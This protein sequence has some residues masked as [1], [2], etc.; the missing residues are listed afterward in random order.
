M[1]L[2]STGWTKHVAKKLKKLALPGLCFG[3]IVQY[4]SPGLLVGVPV[5]RLWLAGWCTYE[6]VE[7]LGD[8]SVQP[9]KVVEQGQPQL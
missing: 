1:C 6:L 8:T 7:L 3:T 5:P 4:S 2:T 9:F